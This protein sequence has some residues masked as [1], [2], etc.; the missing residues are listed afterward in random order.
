MGQFEKLTIN[1]ELTPQETSAIDTLKDVKTEDLK[2]ALK[3]EKLAGTDQNFLDMAA[4][5]STYNVK[6]KEWKTSSDDFGNTTTSEGWLVCDE[7]S[8]TRLKDMIADK[9]DNDFAYLL[10]KVSE[11]LKVEKVKNLETK[12]IGKE[13]KD[14]LR[15]LKTEIEKVSAPTATPVDSTAVSP[16]IPPIPTDS[17]KTPINPPVPTWEKPIAP[18]SPEKL[19]VEEIWNFPLYGKIEKKDIVAAIAKLQETL[20]TEK[21]TTLADGKTT[22]KDIIW[23]LKEG[24]VKELQLALGMKDDNKTALY[25]R[26]DGLFGTKTLKNIEAGKVIV[27][28][29][30]TN[31]AK[32]TT[33]KQKTEET[34]EY[35]DTKK[36]EKKE[37]DNFWNEILSITTT[38]D[39]PVSHTRTEKKVYAIRFPGVEYK[40]YGNWRATITTDKSIEP[41]NTDDIIE[42]VMKL[43]TTSK[44]LDNPTSTNLPTIENPI[45]IEDKVTKPI[46]ENAFNAYKHQLQEEIRWKDYFSTISDPKILEALW[47]SVWTKNKNLKL[48]IADYSQNPDIGVTINGLKKWGANP[49]QTVTLYS[50]KMNLSEFTEKNPDWS[51]RIVDIKKF[52]D[53]VSKH[54]VEEIIKEEEIK[55]NTEKLRNYDKIAEEVKEKA[56]TMKDLFPNVNKNEEPFY[57]EF[58]KSLGENNTLKFENVELWDHKKSLWLD[59]DLNDKNY[60][61]GLIFPMERMMDDKWAIHENNFKKMLALYVKEIVKDHFKDE[62]I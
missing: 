14:Q 19:T 40:F 22:V 4:A 52:N 20:K 6:Y 30:K 39:L 33:E 44:P 36:G 28:K 26:A 59:L 61:K 8:P 32:T 42:E 12:K 13:T 34:E 53:N 45:T 56:Y 9:D 62:S 2:S 23:Y 15:T 1:N 35:T 60:G 24:K 27:Q 43:E 25:Q 11:T 7:N 47:V 46:K 41:K 55:K 29:E 38:N 18:V 48:A 31:T 17:T 51:G 16:I 58:F 57:K 10:Y 5:F 54:V 37:K 49:N 3:T 50:F 21:K